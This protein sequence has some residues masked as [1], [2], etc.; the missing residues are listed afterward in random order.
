MKSPNTP[1]GRGPQIL[2]ILAEHGPLSV[3]G[4]SSIIEPPI[5][6]RKL[7]EV[8]QRLGERQLIIKRHAKIY[9]AGGVF[10]QI[11]QKPK[12]WKEVSTIIGCAPNSLFQPQFRQIEYLHSECCAVW[13][14]EFCQQFENVAVLRDF[15]IRSSNI[16]RE[17]LL[18]TDNDVD[19]LPDL[20]LILQSTDGSNL[21]SV[22]VEIERYMKT[23][24]RTLMK[25]RKFAAE[26]RLDGV[27][28][29]CEDDGI[30]DRLRRLYVNRVLPKANRINNYGHNF[31]LFQDDIFAAKKTTFC[32]QN[33][34][35][36]NIHIHSWMRQLLSTCLHERFDANFVVRPSG[37]GQLNFA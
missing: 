9:G 34:A 14:N 13:A 35:H 21:I 3:R 36:D 6:R 20:L 4:L 33:T 32:L 10:Y 18:E 30:S 24:D 27:I 1:H 26:S 5:A 22:A 2:S 29:F 37:A 15:Q 17:L 16:A 28:W 31:M 7:K 12:V 8:L 19:L 25:L 23:D 11:K